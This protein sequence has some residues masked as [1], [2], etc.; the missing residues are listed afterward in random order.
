QVCVRMAFDSLD[1]KDRLI[2]T[3]FCIDQ[4]RHVEIAEILGVPEG[5]VWSRL[6]HA[7]KR[8]E[9]KVKLSQK[10]ESK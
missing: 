9:Q 1:A 7:K 5:T 4:L 2:L 6:H 8:L 3:L 10:G